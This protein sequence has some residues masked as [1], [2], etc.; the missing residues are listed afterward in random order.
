MPK[1]Y[2]I[3]FL[4]ILLAL[5]PLICFAVIGVYYTSQFKYYLKEIV[6]FGLCTFILYALGFL[7]FKGSSRL[8]WFFVSTTFLYLLSILKTG[9]YYL[10]Q[11][12]INISAFYIV[13][14]TTGNESAG[15]MATY[16]EPGL[17][18]L[19]L[20]F[21]IFLFW[22]FK[23]LIRLYK[24]E[25]WIFIAP[26]FKLK[27][28]LVFLILIGGI[29]GSFY[30]INLKLRGNNIIHLAKDSYISYIE[31]QDLF[32]TNLVKPTSEHFTN[33][34]ASDSAQT[35][36][37]II[38]ESTSSRNMGLYGYYRNT[39]PLLSS[40]DNDEIVVFK[41]VIS[42]H[43]HTIPSLNKALSLANYENPDDLY[44]GSIVQLANAAGF[45]TYWISNQQPIGIHET[46]LTA[47]SKATK[48]Q[49][50]TNALTNK[51]LEYDEALFPHIQNVLKKQEPKKVIFIHLTGTHISYKF[52]YPKSFE[53]FTD[54]PK[55]K[56]PSARSKEQ[57][58]HYDNSIVYN[59]YIVYTIIQEVKKTNSNSYVVYF[60]D[61]GDEVFQDLDFVG[62]NEYHASKPMHE[63]PFILWASEK[64]QNFNPRYETL[65][66][67][68]HRKYMLDDFIHSFSDLSQIKFDEWQPQRSIFN[69]DFVKR[70]RIIKKQID[71]DNR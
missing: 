50:F 6:D 42:P 46:L 40:L 69:P 61:H 24:T 18:L 63:I 49:I 4:G 36:I 16:L 55:T 7:I 59:D 32:Q 21:V 19:L 38:G 33:V 23:I 66:N 56:F 34:K 26:A 14:E 12:K 68:T 43:T 10:F 52:T 13:F 67:Y 28:I 57:I 53:R 64:Y 1:K 39:N 58:N 2:R 25:N 54:T 60:S 45:A 62:H 8:Y 41:D 9:F 5:F 17:I 70:T 15:F 51:Q 20:F 3:L 48:E 22:H 27:N 31:A 65:K 35:Y 29:V 11:S 47:M 30:T 44:K 71:Y 37:V